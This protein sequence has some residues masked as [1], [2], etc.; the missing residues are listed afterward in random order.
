[1][2]K[3]TDFKLNRIYNNA[4]YNNAG[5]QVEVNPP[6]LAAISS[7][8]LLSNPYMHIGLDYVDFTPNTVNG[9]G[10]HLVA[11]AYPKTFIGTESIQKL[12]IGAVQTFGNQQGPRR[13]PTVSLF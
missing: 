7:I 11:K 4:F 2:D 12:D 10:I 6:F 8:S 5:N 1:M 13:N 9:S 3:P